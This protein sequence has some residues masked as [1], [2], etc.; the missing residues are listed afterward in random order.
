MDAITQGL[1]GATFGQAFF[2][3]K[4]GRKALL[5]GAIGG[6]IP[7]LD[8]IPTGLM[9]DPMA[10][11]LWHRGPSHALW[12]GPVVGS[13]LG[14]LL[15]RYYARKLERDP[16]P[17]P[18]LGPPHP[19][20]PEVMWAWIGVMVISIFTHPLLDVFTSY[21]TQLLSP[22]DDHRFVIN[23]IGIIDPMYSLTLIVGLLFVRRARDKPR[24]AQIAA[25][26][27][28]TLTSAYIGYC[29]M[30]NVKAEEAAAEQLEAAGFEPDRIN[31]YPTVF[32]PWLR[33]V[34]AF[35]DAEVRV[36]YLSTWKVVD[37]EWR[38]FAIPQDDPRV[39][40]V[41]ATREGQI[42]A[43]FAMGQVLPVIIELEGRTQIKLADMRYGLAGAD[44][45]S[46]WGVR[47]EVTEE[48]EVVGTP[49]PYR[50]EMGD[51]G[52]AFSRLWEL[53]FPD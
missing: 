48:A 31:A 36:G 12:F 15:W 44:A 22:F 46:M 21:G 42:F 17:A 13:L 34:V 27:T 39:E 28:L 6:I 45:P 7:D 41:T 2:E 14:Y 25:L 30:Q 3:R 37:A 18:P 8:L 10:G 47:A 35:S 50:E 9:A 23:A 33:R 26:A 20:S 11:W 32:Q 53:T 5:W 1:L 16:S 29:Y 40:A 38:T 4:L 52:A 24:R 49:E 43:W 51:T 19:G